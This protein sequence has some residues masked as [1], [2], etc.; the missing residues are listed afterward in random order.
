MIGESVQSSTRAQLRIF[1]FRTPLQK[2][3][4]NIIVT[5]FTYKTKAE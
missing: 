2:R 1:E 4:S 3:G 5:L